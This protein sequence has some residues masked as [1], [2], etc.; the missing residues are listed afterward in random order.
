MHQR[1]RA[2]LC[3]HCASQDRIA[4]GIEL[5]RLDWIATNCALT[6]PSVPVLFDTA[7]LRHQ[8]EWRQKRSAFNSALVTNLLISWHFSSLSFH[9]MTLNSFFSLSG[10]NMPLGSLRR[11]F[12]NTEA[13]VCTE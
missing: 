8:E 13:I 12:F 6:Q 9:V 7:I 3:K 11:N 4:T 2:H 10:P 1:N 5:N